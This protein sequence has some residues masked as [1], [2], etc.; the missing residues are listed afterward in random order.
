MD[1]S[2]EIRQLWFVA[3]HYFKEA[4]KLKGEYCKY[5]DILLADIMNFYENGIPTEEYQKE[6]SLLVAHLN[7]AAVRLC[8]IN[9]RF[10]KNWNDK[11]FRDYQEELLGNQKK[12][13]NEKHWNNVYLTKELIR[14]KKEYLPLMLRDEV[15]HLEE[16]KN[17]KKREKELI[18]RARHAAIESLKVIEVFTCMQCAI[19]QVEEKL[20]NLNVLTR[21]G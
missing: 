13:E 7:S 16:G 9:E 20:R 1:H 11:I 3:K 6:L 10:R 18:W 14:N 15:G 17:P 19:E 12:L 4:E 2:R 21:V 5:L 8:T